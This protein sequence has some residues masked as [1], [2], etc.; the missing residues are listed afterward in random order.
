MIKKKSENERM[1]QSRLSLKRPQYY[2]TDE[3]TWETKHKV[4]TLEKP[5]DLK[6]KQKYFINQPRNK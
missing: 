1:E 4:K 6:M 5:E 2:R 3:K